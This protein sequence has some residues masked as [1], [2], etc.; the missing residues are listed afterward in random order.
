MNQEH[1]ASETVTPNSPHDEGESY[2]E[3][4]EEEL[5]ESPPRRVWRDWWFGILVAGFGTLMLT[6]FAAPF[7]LDS[8]RPA[9]SRSVAKVEVGPQSGPR[10]V[11]PEPAASV[12][13]PSG[14][15]SRAT[16]PSGTPTM[17]EGAKPNAGGVPVSAAPAPS[18]TA[19]IPRTAVTPPISAESTARE[20]KDPTP[21]GATE[22]F[23]IQVGAF[24]NSKYAAKLG[25]KLTAEHYPVMIRPS[26][27]EA[28]RYV[29]GVGR[30]ADRQRADQVRAELEG[31]GFQGFIVRGERR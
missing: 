3:D 4:E 24:K 28:A 7:L 5:E 22:E 31:K 29:V 16:Q 6:L 30:Y 2:R 20:P 10:T 11:V 15:E 27:S 19:E 18:V 14:Q 26:K 21:N 1:D 13:K 12:S 17:S 23:W 25:A 8:W 9:S